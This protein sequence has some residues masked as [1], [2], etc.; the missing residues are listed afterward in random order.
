MGH[1]QAL[2]G[3]SNERVSNLGCVATHPTYLQGAKDGR[4][5]GL[6]RDEALKTESRELAQSR[7]S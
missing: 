7:I 3:L 2:R 4:L 1:R 6:L 5:G